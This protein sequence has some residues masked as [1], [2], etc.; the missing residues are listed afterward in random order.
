MGPTHPAPYFHPGAIAAP[1][2]A[3]TAPADSTKKAPT[4]TTKKA[5]DNQ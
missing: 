5:E 1:A 2:A 4:D 3:P